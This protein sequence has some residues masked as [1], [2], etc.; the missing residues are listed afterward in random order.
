M[1]RRR[2]RTRHASH[3]TMVTAQVLAIQHA[4]PAVRVNFPAR[5]RMAVATRVSRASLRA[6]LRP[7]NVRAACR[8]PTPMGPDSPPA[9]TALRGRIRPLLMPRPPVTA[10]RVRPG[11]IP[12]SR[13]RRGAHCAREGRTRTTRVNRNV[14]SVLTRPCR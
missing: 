12:Q 2:Y 14:Q 8:A 4:H 7:R 10:C 11:R 5:L 1:S 9:Q 13:G 3:V 6:T